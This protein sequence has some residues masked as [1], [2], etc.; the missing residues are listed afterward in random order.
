MRLRTGL[1]CAA[2]LLVMLTIAAWSTPLP[3]ERDTRHSGVLD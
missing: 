1:A 2:F 3:Q